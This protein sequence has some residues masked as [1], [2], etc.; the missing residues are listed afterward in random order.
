MPAWEKDI[1]EAIEEGIVINPLWAPKQIR[2]QGGKV[3]GIEFMRSMTVFDQE[4]R[5]SLSVDEK[6]TQMVEADTIII[7]IGQAP[8][9]SFLSKDSQLERA[10]WGSLVVDENS[11]STNIPGVFAGGDFTTGP[12]IVINAIASGRRAALAIDKYLKGE[13]GRIEIADEKT[14]MKEDIGLALDEEAAEERPRIKIE[15]EKPEERIKDFREVE[16][17]FTE[18]EAHREAIRCL[19]C[20]LEEK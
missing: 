12:S 4:G 20:D 2:H 16:K 9:I 11:L 6:V 18:E 17:G 7:S 14:A 13:R 19:R 5:S 3:T 15:L 10:L 8:D 1:E